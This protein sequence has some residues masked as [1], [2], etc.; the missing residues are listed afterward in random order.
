MSNNMQ[1]PYINPHPHLHAGG[2]PPLHVDLVQP[3]GSHDP[4]DVQNKLG[5]FAIQSA[6]FGPPKP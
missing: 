4:Q 5:A 6:V 3:N 2:Q 1:P